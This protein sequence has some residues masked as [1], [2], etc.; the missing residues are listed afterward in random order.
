PVVPDG[1]VGGE[2]LPWVGADEPVVRPFHARESVAG[3]AAGKIDGSPFVDRPAPLAEAHS[4]RPYVDVPGRD[5]PLV[6]GRAEAEPLGKIECGRFSDGDVHLL[7]RAGASR[8]E[9]EHEYCRAPVH[10]SSPSPYVTD[11]SAATFQARM[12]LE[13]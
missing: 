10:S 13:W 3:G 5:A 7:L 12:K 2:V 1:G 11:P 9:E 8:E 6:R 4:I